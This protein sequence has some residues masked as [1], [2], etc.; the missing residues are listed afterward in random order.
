MNSFINKIFDDNSTLHKVIYFPFQG[1]L[2]ILNILS[3]QFFQNYSQYFV[4]INISFL[5]TKIYTMSLKIT[6]SKSLFF[7]LS[8][9]NP[10]IITILLTLIKPLK[11]DEDLTIGIVIFVLLV[12]V[13]FWNYFKYQF[14]YFSKEQWKFVIWFNSTDKNE[15][16]IYGKKIHKDILKGQKNNWIIFAISILI[17]ASLIPFNIF[18]YMIPKEIIYYIYGSSSVFLFIVIFIVNF[19][20]KNVNSSL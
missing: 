15:K 4:A 7:W 11:N 1:I 10:L 13:M 9:F 3:F 6:T 5:L 20:R 8:I 17:I 2:L 14:V 19:R 18:S 12:K 16:E